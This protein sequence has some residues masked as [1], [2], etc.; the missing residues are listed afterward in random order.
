MTEG[1]GNDGIPPC[2]AHWTEHDNGFFQGALV[3]GALHLCPRLP[4][5]IDPQKAR[6]EE[7]VEDNP[8]DLVPQITFVRRSEAE[9]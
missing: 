8:F 6:W 1:L 4:K 9:M 2:A 3:F 7:G 5:G